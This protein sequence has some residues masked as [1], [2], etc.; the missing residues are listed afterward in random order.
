MATAMMAGGVRTNV[1]VKPLTN[2]VVVRLMPPPILG[3]VLLDSVMLKQ[4]P[5]WWGKVEAIGVDVKLVGVGDR[6][7][8]P[9][10]PFGAVYE[11]LAPLVAPGQ[12]GSGYVYRAVVSEDALLGVVE[13]V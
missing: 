6:V 10:R 3:D 4:L 2:H 11:E 5:L 7:I 13:S 9:A 8:L 1:V 12:S